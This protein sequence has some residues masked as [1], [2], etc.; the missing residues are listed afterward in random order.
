MARYSGPALA[1]GAI[2]KAIGDIFEGLLAGQRGGLEAERKLGELGLG[3]RELALKAGAFPTERALVQAQTG[4]ASQEAA[5]RAAESERIYRMT[6]EEIGQMRAETGRAL[7]QADVYRGQA[8][9]IGMENRLQQQAI[10]DWTQTRT[11]AQ[12]KG[13]EVTQQDIYAFAQRHPV[14][15]A[16][17]QKMPVSALWDLSELEKY[18]AQLKMQDPYKGPQFLLDIDKQAQAESASFVKQ[19]Y[20]EQSEKPEAL[21]AQAWMAR[22]NRNR[23]LFATAVPGAKELVQPAGWAPRPLVDLMV[24]AI[25][26]E[27]PGVDYDSAR[28]MSSDILVRIGLGATTWQAELQGM[29][30]MSKG[31]P[32]P[33]PSKAEPPAA[34]YGPPGATPGPTGPTYRYK[35]R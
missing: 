15:M 6:P 3:E 16:G 27:V 25:Q 18:I 35:P 2:S 4:L 9:G 34:G 30:N 28:T 21:D 22:A 7:G 33:H 13:R 24:K 14:L 23:L 31:A 5:K 12:A 29:R 8:F 26:R 20:G 19:L 17:P 1:A 11:A 10:D 32:A